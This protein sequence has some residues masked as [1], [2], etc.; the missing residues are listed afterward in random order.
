MKTTDTKTIYVVNRTHINNIPVETLDPDGT[1]ER[2]YLT[3]QEALYSLSDDKDPEPH[4][5]VYPANTV[6][7]V[8]NI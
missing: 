4:D 1:W 8:M 2:P 5:L 6:F 7:K 3:I